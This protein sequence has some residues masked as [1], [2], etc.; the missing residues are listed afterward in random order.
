MSFNLPVFEELKGGEWVSDDDTNEM[1][2]KT[3]FMKYA[4]NNINFKGAFDG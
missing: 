4:S 2:L 1:V 3:G